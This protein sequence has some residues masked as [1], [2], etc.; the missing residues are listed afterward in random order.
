M[1]AID[2]DA[3]FG[4]KSS[5]KSFFGYKEHIAMT[6]EE[7]ITA[8][9]VTGGSSEDGKQFKELLNQSLATGIE[10]DEVIADTAYSGK[11]N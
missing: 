1:S 4:W 5:T 11:D 10:V 9:T 6:E 7:M 2:P 8:V 3:R